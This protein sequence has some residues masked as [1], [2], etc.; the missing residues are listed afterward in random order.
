MALMLA[1]VTLSFVAAAT[2]TR[3][4]LHC[5]LLWVAVIFATGSLAEILGHLAPGVNRQVS[6]QLTTPRVLAVLEFSTVSALAIILNQYLRRRLS[7][8]IM[9]LVFGSIGTAVIG[10]AWG[11][12]YF[13]HP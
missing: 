10:S 12:Y 6:A 2:C 1:S 11:Y 3:N 5:V 4:T 13:F 9:L 8:S 7:V